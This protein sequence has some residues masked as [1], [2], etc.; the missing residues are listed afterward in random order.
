MR[1]TRLTAKLETGPVAEW[2]RYD[3]RRLQ[4]NYRKM[5]PV[6][7]RDEQGTERDLPQ[8]AKSGSRLRP[9]LVVEI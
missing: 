6:S 2:L 1:T 5:L 8:E 4:F 3:L 9:I 7:P